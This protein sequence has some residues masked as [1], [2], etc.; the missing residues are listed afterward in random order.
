LTTPK[1]RRTLAAVAALIAAAGVGY[2]L[3]AVRGQ[4]ERSLLG[5]VTGAGCSG[6]EAISGSQRVTES[7]LNSIMKLTDIAKAGSLIDTAKSAATEGTETVL[8]LVADVGRGPQA[9]PVTLISSP[10]GPLYPLGPL[11]L[12]MLSISI[13][14]ENKSIDKLGKL[15]L[16]LSLRFDELLPDLERIGIRKV[17]IGGATVDLTEAP[18]SLRRMA[19]SNSETP[20]KIFRP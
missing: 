19:E 15:Y 6:I 17:D 5:C 16:E 13:Q 14:K 11:I 3:L 12:K 1:V 18:A 4:E 7:Q 8:F 10:T 2:Y 9:F 20:L